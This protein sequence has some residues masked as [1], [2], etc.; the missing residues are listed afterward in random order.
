LLHVAITRQKKSLYIGITPKN[1]N[2]DIYR[3]FKLDIEI[4]IMPD[5]NEVDRT[6]KY[7]KLIDYA[8]N[9]NKYFDSISTKYHDIREE[10]KLDLQRENDIIDWGHHV[11]RWCIF[12]TN[13]KIFMMID[14]QTKEYGELSKHQMLTV[15]R[16]IINCKPEKLRE[17]EYFGRLKTLKKNKST[18]DKSKKNV[19]ENCFP[20][21]IF[22]AIDKII[23]DKY[24]DIIIDYIEK[25]KIKLKSL[26]AMKHMSE[27]D[28]KMRVFCPLESVILVHMIQIYQDHKYADISIKM[29]YDLISYYS[30]CYNACS[31]DID[32][33]HDEMECLCEKYFKTN[34]KHPEKNEK[35]IEE[36]K[37]SLKNHYEKVKYT[38]RIFDN[39]KRDISNNYGENVL[40]TY[41][42]NHL[43]TLNNKDDEGFMFKRKLYTIAHSNNPGLM[44]NFRL[45][46]Q[47]TSLNL[48]EILFGL[49][50]DNYIIHKIGEI[51]SDT[52]NHKRFVNREIIHIVFTLDNDIPYVIKFEY[53]TYKYLIE[54]CIKDYLEELTTKYDNIIYNYYKYWTNNINDENTGN[55]MDFVCGEIRKNIDK[56][57]KYIVDHFEEGRHEFNTVMSKI[58]KLYMTNKKDDEIQK[59][60][61]DILNRFDDHDMFLSCI[62]VRHD[63]YIDDFLKSVNI[64]PP[65]KCEDIYNGIE[66]AV[67]EQDIG[68]K[69]I[70]DNKED[71]PNDLP[72]KNKVTKNYASDPDHNEEIIKKIKISKIGSNERKKVQNNDK[73]VKVVAKN[74]SEKNPINLDMLIASKPKKKEFKCNVCNRDINE[75]T[76]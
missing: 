51:E 67:N 54:Q 63:K 52:P 33:G 9:N 17:K 37:M 23:F 74:R 38:K 72:T 11:I 35:Q 69:I 61:D 65:T 2:D 56:I 41:N 62:K 8:C 73:V 24:A 45:V 21:F 59:K 53:D 43:L 58:I 68:N 76:D 29:V 30:D 5:L 26:V 47:I 40:L 15:M 55:K 46:P 22:N 28:D 13:I 42:F 20:V 39:Y 57:P 48:D 25:I 49:I 36:I 16:I 27:F 64:T 66:Q 7:D 14:E 31:N 44:I 60:H 12:D 1:E 34:I 6:I 3:R 19:S 50:F 10:L 75:L 32:N 71:E 18:N 70:S 4:P